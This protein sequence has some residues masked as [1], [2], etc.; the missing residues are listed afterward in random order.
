MVG[1]TEALD[2]TLLKFRLFPR[3][4]GTHHHRTAGDIQVDAVV[5]SD[6]DIDRRLRRQAIPDGR[7]FRGIVVNGAGPAYQFPPAVG[8]AGPR[9]LAGTLGFRGMRSG[10]FTDGDPRKIGTYRFC[11]L[12]DGKGDAIQTG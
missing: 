8:V 4:W 7:Q 6:T 5:M 11:F 9:I 12:A 2:D 10:H 3:P 1:R